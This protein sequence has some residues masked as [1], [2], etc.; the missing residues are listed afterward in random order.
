[1]FWA[2][3]KPK[4]RQAWVVRS[5]RCLPPSGRGIFGDCCAN[6]H[7]IRCQFLKYCCTF[8]NCNCRVIFS[9]SFYTFYVFCKFFILILELIFWNWF[10]ENILKMAN[11]L[12][13]NWSTRIEW[14]CREQSVD[15]LNNTGCKSI[16]NQKANSELK[17]YS[18][19]EVC[20]HWWWYLL[21]WYW[22]NLKE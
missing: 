7:G 21:Q 1:M 18:E 3:L 19:D 9:L 10:F 15:F 16:K 6:N 5:R 11:L 14:T 13:P 2:G 17:K 8:M 20:Q 4:I 22:C 12:K